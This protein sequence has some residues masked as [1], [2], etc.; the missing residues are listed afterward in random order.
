MPAPVNTFKAALQTRGDLLTGL[1]VALA[2]PHSAEICAGAGF[3]WILID[4][5]H[6]PNDIPLIAAQLAAVTRH[7]AHPVVRLPVGEVWMIKQALDIGAQTLMIPMVETA[8]QAAL[9]AKALRYPP[10]GIRGMGAS[11]G[12]A[13]NFGRI[14]DYAET[15]N[16]QVCL[17]AQIE[18]RLGVENA[19]A[20]LATEGVDAVLIGPA[21]LSADMGYRG[22][23][24][25]PEVMET[26]EALIG[27][28]K[29]AGKPAGIM[30]G[31][32]EMITLARRAGVRFM[33][34]ATD[35]GLLAKAA[36]AMAAEM[37]NPEAASKGGISSGSGGY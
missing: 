11:L 28:I 5:E 8:E 23:A 4:A 2:N 17:I 21:D 15:A 10:D 7:A 24:T 12:R 34:N 13:S 32:P 26:V 33:A 37:R 19:E 18:S 9:L 25:V 16:D 27:K 20:I 30:T 3:D 22:K 6:G 31:D 35:T 14:A 29:A 1:W 36:A